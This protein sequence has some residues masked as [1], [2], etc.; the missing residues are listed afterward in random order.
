M[1][2]GLQRKY[3]GRGIRE[4]HREPPTIAQPCTLTA[5]KVPEV[6]TSRFYEAVEPF[7]RACPGPAIAEKGL[8]MVALQWVP[9]IS[10][11][12][13]VA[14]RATPYGSRIPGSRNYS[15]TRP[16]IQSDHSERQQPLRT[17]KDVAGALYCTPEHLSRSAHDRGYSYSL[18]VRWVRF[19]LGIELRKQGHGGK[20]IARRLGM[21]DPASWTRFVQRLIGR[22]PK[23]LPNL[24]VEE[25]AKEGIM[26]VFMVPLRTGVPLS[27]DSEGDDLPEL[28]E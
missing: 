4:P 1:A 12:P 13:T 14:E 23:Q 18:A 2:G 17:V 15:P 11:Q 28:E 10:P 22:S 9:G 25:W 20:S 19:L 21:P 6:E 24:A 5:T 7:L 3:V 26:R 16:G 8:R 27:E